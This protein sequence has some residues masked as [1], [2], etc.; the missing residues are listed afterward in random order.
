VGAVSYERNPGRDLG[1]GTA[2]KHPLRPPNQ[3]AGIERE[4]EGE[5]GRRKRERARER[6]GKRGFSFR[7]R[8]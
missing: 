7:F 5:R 3:P 2:H 4:T 8:V 1:R 6:V